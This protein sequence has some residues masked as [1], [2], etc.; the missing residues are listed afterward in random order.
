MEIGRVV[1]GGPLQ[2]MLNSKFSAV[3]GRGRIFRPASLPPPRGPT[4]KINRILNAMLIKY[5]GK[6]LR[7]RGKS[8]D[9]PGI[10]C[11]N[12]FNRFAWETWH[13]KSQV[14]VILNR[15][16]V[17]IYT[18]RDRE[19]ERERDREGQWKSHGGTPAPRARER[20]GWIRGKRADDNFINHQQKSAILKKKFFCSISHLSGNNFHRFRVNANLSVHLHKLHN[21]INFAVVPLQLKML[22]LM[23]N[24]QVGN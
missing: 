22:Q 20:P 9:F 6:Q 14:I 18:E 16:F 17:Y 1:V 13:C 7:I 5:R 21:F 15:N 2:T 4:T 10:C 19:R 12:K 11:R 3:S 8:S 23:W 24:T